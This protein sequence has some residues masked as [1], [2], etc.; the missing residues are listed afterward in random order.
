MD[1][2]L[3][4]VSAAAPADLRLTVSP[5]AGSD[6]IVRWWSVV[7][8]S[9]RL[10][11][12]AVSRAEFDQ[13]VAE[14]RLLVA[15]EHADLVQPF[16]GARPPQAVSG[17][18]LSARLAMMPGALA[19]VPAD[20]VTV[21]VRALTLDGADPVAGEGDLDAYPFVTRA[22]VEVLT[23]PEQNAS[24]AVALMGALT[25]PEPPPV[26]L[27]FTGD[28]IP[29]RCVYERM[30]RGGDWSAPF[31]PLGERLRGADV[32]IASLDAAISAQG[33]PI[34]CRQTFSLLAPPLVVE[35]FA[36][37]GFDVITV[38]TNHVKDC[39]E[40]SDCGDATFLDTLAALRGAGIR[41]VGGGTTLAEARRP[42]V[43]HAGGVRLAFLAYD[44]IAAHL[45][46]A[47]SRPGTAPL[48]P[49]TLAADIRAAREL[50]DVVIVLPH[51]GDEYTA[52]PTARQQSAA[53]TA[54]GAGATLV[55]GNHPHAVQA[56]APLADGYV[57]YALGNFLFDQDWSPEPTESVLLE[58]LFRGPRLAAVRFLPVR[59]E[60]QLRTVPLPDADARRV[61]ARM[62]DAA[63]RLAD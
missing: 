30:R 45:H 56:A 61:L 8:G 59:T 39:G 21:R 16:T 15:T 53:A 32:T 52:H 19:L 37:A 49:G 41:P 1:R 18:E 14:G 38:A 11:L 54:I 9:A 47:E 4:A 58:A 28:I 33:R 22:R 23:D 60:D 7:A 57:A 34:G 20:R 2:S 24:L 48:D 51:W 63:A 17:P 29:A 13:A 31:R 46:A 35:G 6:P 12:D 25:R 36:F 10:D 5:P 55:V 40:R 62:M 50:A 42:V 3:I 27:T 43:V 44:D 26:R